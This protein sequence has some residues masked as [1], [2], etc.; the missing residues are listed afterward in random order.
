M[1]NAPQLVIV[2]QKDEGT[3]LRTIYNFHE[4]GPEIVVSENGTISVPIEAGE[5]IGTPIV[6]TSAPS[7]MPLSSR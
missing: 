6:T 4:G 5:R 3:R 2:E 1:T 7:C